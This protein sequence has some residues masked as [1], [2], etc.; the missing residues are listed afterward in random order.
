MRK[1]FP[2]RSLPILLCGLAL[3]AGCDRAY[4]TRQ[5]DDEVPA[6]NAWMVRTLNDESVE[7]AV[8]AQRTIYP[9]HFARDSA[10]LTPVGER[11]MR[12]LGAHFAHSPGSLSVR[13]GAEGSDLYQARLRSVG[14]ALTRAG[15]DP[16]AIRIADDMPGGEGVN[17]ERAVAIL[18]ISNTPAPAGAPTGPGSATTSGGSKR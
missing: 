8:I 14:D 12:I 4:R 5:I 15:V 3:V 13:R 17:S 16:N 11:D 7:N 10:E 1:E 6:A 9:Y 18:T 2:V